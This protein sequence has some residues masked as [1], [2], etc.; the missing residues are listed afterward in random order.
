MWPFSSLEDSA[1]DIFQV[2]QS[3]ASVI[4]LL[5]ESSE[6][7]QQQTTEE[8]AA[9]IM[10]LIRQRTSSVGTWVT[11]TTWVTQNLSSSTME[12]IEQV[13]GD[14]EAASIGALLERWTANETR[15]QRAA[16]ALLGRTG[17]Q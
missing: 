12:S 15:S 13:V 11:D 14:N 5:K 4:S 3:L 10:G 2:T 7:V 1:G 8:V 6:L 16:A 17:V 9:N